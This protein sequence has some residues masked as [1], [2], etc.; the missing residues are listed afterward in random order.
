MT[1]PRHNMPPMFNDTDKFDR[2]NWPTWSN[3]ILSIAALKGITGYFNGTIKKNPKPTSTPPPET[4]W[5][6][7][8]PS[9]SEWEARNA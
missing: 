2:T 8:N 5:N 1:L 3:N 4:P 9:D 6:S 7:L